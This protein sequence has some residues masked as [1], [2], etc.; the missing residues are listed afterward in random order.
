MRRVCAG[1]LGILL[2]VS[3]LSSCGNTEVEETVAADNTAT[4]T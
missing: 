3:L 1:L 2:L 4:E